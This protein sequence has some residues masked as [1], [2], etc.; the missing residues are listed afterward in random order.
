MYNKLIRIQLSGKSTKYET[1]FKV[2]RHSKL[3]SGWKG[4][5]TV[6]SLKT[7]R[8]NKHSVHLTY[9]SSTW[10]STIHIKYTTTD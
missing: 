4:H 9:L 5:E 10:K 6:D 2:G 7:L 1:Y 3:M 8:H